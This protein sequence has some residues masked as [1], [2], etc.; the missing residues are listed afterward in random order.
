[1]ASKRKNAAKVENIRPSEVAASS[2]KPL[3]ELDE[4][5]QMRLIEQSGIL[6]RMKKVEVEREIDGMEYVEE[7]IPLAEE[8]LNA[9][10]YIIPTS[11][12][13][14]MMEILVH[15]QYQQA[16][17]IPVIVERMVSGIPIISLFVFYTLR[18]KSYRPLQAVLFWV[19][20][21]SSS[22][23]IYQFNNASF[24]VNMQQAPPLATLWIFAVVMLDLGPAVLSLLAAGWF[25]WW[26]DLKL[27]F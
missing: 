11:F 23:L 16:T 17:S 18:Y 15:Q 4:A 13:L 9:V 25:I 10:I 27:L 2:S 14:L 26:K 21:L 24:L 22:R 5:E 3:I 12:L 8:I 7:R 1:M 19:S 20:V 6:E